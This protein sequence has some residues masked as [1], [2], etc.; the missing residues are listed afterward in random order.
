MWLIIFCSGL[1]KVINKWLKEGMSRPLIATFF[2]MV[3]CFFFPHFYHFS[4]ALIVGVNFSSIIFVKL[5]LKLL[6]TTCAGTFTSGCRP[7]C[8][9]TALTT[10]LFLCFSPQ[11]ILQFYRR[12][13]MVISKKTI[14]FQGSR[15]CPTFSRGEGGPTLSRGSKC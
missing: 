10:F 14:I 6:L 1:G 11:L 2:Q 9:K 8:H 7:D 13:P 12:C 15:G 5:V 4:S 3:P